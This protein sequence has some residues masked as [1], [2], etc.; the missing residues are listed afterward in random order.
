MNDAPPLNDF[1]GSRAVLVG[2]WDYANLPKIDAAQHS[3]NRM[4]ALLVGDLLV[5]DLCGWPASRVSVI[6][7]RR[8]PGD[9]PDKLNQLFSQ[10]GGVALFYYVG[11][12][13]PD[14]HDRLCL[15]LVES[16]TE[17]ERRLSVTEG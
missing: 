1:S 14:D 9:L 15:G 11:H 10:V 16:R 5:G 3:L 4:K 8:K 17:A 13:Q 2:T 7:N 12:G 6:R